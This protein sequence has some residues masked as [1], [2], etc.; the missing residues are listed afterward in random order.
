MVIGIGGVLFLSPFWPPISLQSP[1]F[2]IPLL[3]ST[4]GSTWVLVHAHRA[5]SAADPAELA[6]TDWGFPNARDLSACATVVEARVAAVLAGDEVP[7][8]ATEVRGE[9]ARARAGRPCKGTI[10]PSSLARHH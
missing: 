7:P 9:S 4:H 8:G 10:E 5:V 2:F 1:F 6:P 3:G